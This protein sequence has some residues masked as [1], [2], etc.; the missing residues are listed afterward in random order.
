MSH[1]I[2]D[3]FLPE[4]KL[5]LI[6]NV[7]M[8]SEFNWFYQPAVAYDYQKDSG[9]LFYFTHL[10]Y[11]KNIPISPFYNF[12]NEN[13][14][15]HLKC[16]SLIRVKANLYPNQNEKKTNGIH[17]DYDFPHKGAIFY[18]NTNNGKTILDKKIEIDSVEN[19]LLLFDSH[20]P[21]DSQNC[22]D[23]KVRV[24]ININYF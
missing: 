24:N 11:E 9:I 7:I 22:V 8:G 10:F 5:K 17:I 23:Q 15:S 20:L 1:Q 16:K 3:N 19:R 13:L 18:I 4:K 21:H 6:K 14:I 12:I 2:I